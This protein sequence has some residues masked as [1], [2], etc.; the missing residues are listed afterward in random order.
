MW[1]KTALRLAEGDVQLAQLMY[2]NERTIAEE[3]YAIHTRLF[4]AFC[5]AF[6]LENPVNN[7]EGAAERVEDVSRWKLLRTLRGTHW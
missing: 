7:V 3:R 1:K 6:V 5:N 4:D 2:V